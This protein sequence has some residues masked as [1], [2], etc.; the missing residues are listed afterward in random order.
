[1]LALAALVSGT[2]PVTL[3]WIDDADNETGFVLER[4]TDAKTWQP[5]GGAAANA[6]AFKDTTALQGVKYY[7]R[8]KAT[9]SSGDSAWSNIAGGIRKARQTL[10]GGVVAADTAWSAGSHYVVTNSLTV[11]AGVTL[12]IPPGTQ[13]CFDAGQ[14]LTVANGGRLLAEGTTNAPI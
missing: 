2:D 6:G 10:V 1:P 3:A 11:A 4:S 13:V 14:G 8:A 9:N 5:L 7:Y 12:T